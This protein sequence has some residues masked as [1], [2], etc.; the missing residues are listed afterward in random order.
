MAF[1]EETAE[2]QLFRKLKRPSALE[3]LQKARNQ[4][5]FEKR[6]F[7]L[8][9]ANLPPAMDYMFIDPTFIIENGWWLSEF[10]IEIHSLLYG[11]QGDYNG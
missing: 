1:G 6:W 7:A 11:K 10:D 5:A 9:T 8:Q 2:D 4:L 3:L